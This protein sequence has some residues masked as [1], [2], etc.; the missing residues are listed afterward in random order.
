[1][2]SPDL[3]RGGLDFLFIFRR[4]WSGRVDEHTDAGVFRN[5]FGEKLQT[6]RQQ[7]ARGHRDASDI[8]A[9]TIETGDQSRLQYDI[10]TQENDRNTPRRGS[11]RFHDGGPASRSNH[12]DA[13]VDQIGGAWR[14][15]IVGPFRPAVFDV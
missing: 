3:A 1:N 15:A 4:F 2:L 12:A 8:A 13:A 5:E 9:W 11:G 14:Q 10:A 6:F 7:R